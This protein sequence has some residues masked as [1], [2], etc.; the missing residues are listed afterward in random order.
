[1]VD[2][3]ELVV[4]RNDAVF[5]TFVFFGMKIKIIGKLRKVKIKNN[6]MQDAYQYFKILV[7]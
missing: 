6:L 2:G 4:V 5:R 1:M 3:T 7:D